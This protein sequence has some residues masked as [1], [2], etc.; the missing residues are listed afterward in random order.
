M[1]KKWIITGIVLLLLIMGI[2]IFYKD[3]II[4]DEERFLFTDAPGESVGKSYIDGEV[5]VIDKG[6]P[7][8]DGIG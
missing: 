8:F 6:D 3:F 7:Y 4:S 2:F 1:K 5:F